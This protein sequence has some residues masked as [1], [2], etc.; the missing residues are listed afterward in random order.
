MTL[1]VNFDN[2]SSVAVVTKESL[3]RQM[4]HHHIY[5]YASYPDTL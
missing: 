5:T 3:D 2:M 1:N 4:E